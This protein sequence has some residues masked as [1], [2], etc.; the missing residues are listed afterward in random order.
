MTVTGKDAPLS[1]FTTARS[2]SG[3]RSLSRLVEASGLVNRVS[4][5]IWTTSTTSTR[6]TVPIARWLT[7]KP[8]LMPPTSLPLT[9]YGTYAGALAQVALMRSA[10][11]PSTRRFSTSTTPRMSGVLRKSQIASEVLVRRL[12]SAA[13]VMVGP[14]LLSFTSSKKRSRLKPPMVTSS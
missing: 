6:S 7:R 5:P 1:W 14:P 13:A 4:L 8:T 2:I 3:G 9:R 11:R 10:S 12:S